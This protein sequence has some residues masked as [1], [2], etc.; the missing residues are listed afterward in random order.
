METSNDFVLFDIE[1][2]RFILKDAIQLDINYAY[3][4]L[5]FSEHGLI[6][7]QF[8]K[9]NQDLLYCWF[10]KDCSLKYRDALFESLKI[11]AGLNKV[12]LEYKGT[13]EMKQKEGKDEIDLRFMAV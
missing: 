6:I 11:T 4:D 10:N 5:L 2:A 12:M 9:E 13:F 8:T 1:K 7:I 3:E